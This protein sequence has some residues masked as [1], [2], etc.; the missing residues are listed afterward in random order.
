MLLERVGKL[1]HQAAGIIQSL[2]DRRKQ[3]ETS[4]A[5]RKKEIENLPLLTPSGNFNYFCL[6]NCLYPIL[7]LL[8]IGFKVE[9]TTQNNKNLLLVFNILSFSVL[10]IILI[11]KNWSFPGAK[12]G[13][14]AVILGFIFSLAL[15]IIYYKFFPVNIQSRNFGF[16]CLDVLST[17]AIPIGHFIYYFIATIYNTKREAM[18]YVEPLGELQAECVKFTHTIHDKCDAAN[19]Y[20]YKADSKAE[21]KV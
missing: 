10:I 21:E 13:F 14:F 17:L 12:S 11:F 4:I 8:A 1:T 20:D 2:E 9:W 15:T 5:N 6:F 7:M 19:E 16:G 3:L 18:R